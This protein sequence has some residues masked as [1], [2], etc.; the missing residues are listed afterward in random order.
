MNYLV[1]ATPGK[2]GGKG[3]GKGAGGGGT[4]VPD[5][6]CETPVGGKDECAI[7]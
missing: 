1:G 3:A 7:F 5:D 4:Y 6:E 2:E